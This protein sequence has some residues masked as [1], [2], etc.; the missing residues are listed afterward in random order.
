MIRYYKESSYSLNKRVII[1]LTA[2]QCQGA[3]ALVKNS[4]YHVH[5]KHI[6]I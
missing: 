6:N 3:M 5:T 1:V 2:V 4:E